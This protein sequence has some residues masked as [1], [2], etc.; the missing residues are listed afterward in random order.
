M[1]TVAIGFPTAPNA[2]M[3]RARHRHPVETY[4]SRCAEMLGQPSSLA[5]GHVCVS[6]CV[7][8]SGNGKTMHAIRIP[9]TPSGR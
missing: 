8:L 3:V 2:K 1:S 4:L 7:Q 6:P 5:L 9:S